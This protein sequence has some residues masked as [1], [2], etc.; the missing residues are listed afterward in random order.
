MVKNFQETIKPLNW[1]TTVKYIQE[2]LTNG[3]IL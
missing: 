1:L 2:N 3:D